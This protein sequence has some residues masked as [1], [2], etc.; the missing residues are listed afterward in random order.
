MYRNILVPI[1]FDGSRDAEGAIAVARKLAN[2]GG[3]ITLLHVIENVPSFALASLPSGYLMHRRKEAEA[4]L[5]AMAADLPNGSSVVITGHSGR[6]I[7]D[8]AADKG[9]DCIVIASHRPGLED[10]LL[11]STATHVVRHAQCSVHVVRSG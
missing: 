11:G 9:V 7:L 4:E 3:A 2:E 1:S 6:S 8:W 5:A 10:L